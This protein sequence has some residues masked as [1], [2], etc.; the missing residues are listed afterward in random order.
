[1]NAS[2]KSTE[3]AESLLWRA[4]YVPIELL[5]HVWPSDVIYSGN[6]LFYFETSNDF[7]C[8]ISPKNKFP[9]RGSTL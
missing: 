5:A 8:S 2:F 1:M 7:V 4:E 3:P 6:V 9:R